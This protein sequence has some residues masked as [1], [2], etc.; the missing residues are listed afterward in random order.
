MTD[1][2]IET[3]GLAI[4][5]GMRHYELPTREETLDFTG[6]LICAEDNDQGDRPRWAELR[7]Y[8]ILVTNPDDDL[9]GQQAWLLYTVGHT[10][11]YHRADGCNRGILLPA[12]DF[13]EQAEDPEGL[14]PCV[15][16]RPPQ[17]DATHPDTPL[18][19]EVT[20]YTYTPC[21]TPD[22]VYSSLCRELQCKNC[23]D[24]PHKTYACSCGCEDYEP[25][26]RVLSVPGRRL[27]EQ[28]R[29]LDPDI[30]KAAARKVRF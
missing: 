7:L 14:E 10:M 27:W 20:W 16:C 26:P 5:A 8:K 11:V 3:D 29:R 15:R 21:E 6:K 2:A 19:L 23:G 22:M 18:R 4:P 9:F 12:G 28:A 30:A 13:D 17:L 25:A 24:K 1:A